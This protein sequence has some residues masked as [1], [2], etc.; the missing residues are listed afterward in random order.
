MKDKELILVS[1]GVCIILAVASI[2]LVG[3]VLETVTSFSQ[4]K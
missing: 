1:L 3:L 2:Q 4:E